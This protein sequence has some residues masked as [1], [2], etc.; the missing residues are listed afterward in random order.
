[1]SFDSTECTWVCGNPARSAGSG[2]KSYTEIVVNWVN[3]CFGGFTVESVPGVE[4]PSALG[5]FLFCRSQSLIIMRD[6][7]ELVRRA[8]VLEATARKPGNVHPGAAFSDLCYADFLQAATAIAPVLSQPNPVGVLILESVRA[9]RRSLT[10]PTNPNLGIILLLAPLCAVPAEV[11][12]VDGIESVLA[13]LTVADCRATYRAIRES[14]PGGMG[15]VAEG[16]LQSEPEITLREAM[17]LAADRDTIAAEYTQGYRVILQ[18]AVPFLAAWSDFPSTWEAALIELH[19]RLMHAV[20]DT[21]IARKCGLEVAQES[22][23]R[24]G[25]VLHATTDRGAALAEFDQWLRADGHRRNPGT[26]ADLIAA[27][28]FAAARDHDLPLPDLNA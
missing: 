4:P 7:A 10:R 16:D 17:S 27:A 12:L 6:L 9:T 13:S 19:L 28:V 1:M 20:P 5:I 14:Q 24:A 15:E 21:L 3:H 23:Q 22:A 18:Q 11:S 26:T 8:C 2:F 25:V